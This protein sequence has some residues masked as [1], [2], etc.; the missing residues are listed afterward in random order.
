MTKTEVG[1][2]DWGEVEARTR[3]L[4]RLERIWSKS[5]NNSSSNVPTATLSSS[6]FSAS[7]EER[8]RKLF[9]DALRDGYVLCQCVFFFFAPIQVI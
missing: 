8:E 3:A 9:S 4:A 5:G 7:G 6:G 1:L 2:R